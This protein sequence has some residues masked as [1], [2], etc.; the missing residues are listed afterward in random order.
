MVYNGGLHIAEGTDHL[1]F[2]LC[3]LLPAPWLL[4]EQRWQGRAG[5][6][7]SALN[8][9][10]IVTA[11]TLGH[12]FTLAL[13]A[14]GIFALPS[15]PVEF[16]VAISVLISAIHAMRPVFG[17]HAVVIAV[18]FGLVH[19]LVFANEMIGKGFAVDAVVSALLALN[20]GVEAMQLLVVLAVLPCLLI[21]AGTRFCSLLRLSF[22]GFAAL[23]V[24][25]RMVERLSDES[26][27]LGHW[28]E[29][30]AGGSVWGLALVQLFSALIYL[31]HRL[32]GRR[33][34]RQAA[35]NDSETPLM[36]WRLPV[37]AGPSSKT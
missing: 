1:L 22:E 18:A 31:S 3:L 14:L 6:R 30:V 8:D 24:G 2:L 13:T 28:V 36:Q 11:F 26:T 25:N 9:G 32:A 21:L 19:G 33:L 29:V 5:V 16:I 10:K 15:R 37:G 4:G 20:L 12:S 34:K 7:A 27:N 17:R 35:L 23:A